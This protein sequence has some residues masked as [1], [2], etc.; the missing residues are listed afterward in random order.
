MGPGRRAG[1]GAW[2]AGESLHGGSTVGSSVMLLLFNIGWY[3]LG[4]VRE[5]RWGL[6]GIPTQR[7]GGGGPTG[8]HQEGAAS[9]IQRK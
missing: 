9:E 8:G 1:T 3:N 7:S 5:Q 2:G 6:Q 4:G